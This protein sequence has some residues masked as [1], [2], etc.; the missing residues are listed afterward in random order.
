VTQVL[1]GAAVGLE[2]LEG[3][4]F[5]KERPYTG[6]CICGAIFQ[7]EADR[8]P[9]AVYQRNPAEFSHRLSN[10]DIYA[11][12]L[13]ENWRQK[14]AKTHPEH[15]HES[16]RKS[17]LWC[18]PEAAHRMAAFGIIPLS[19]ALPESET[20]AA[21]YESSPIPKDDVEGT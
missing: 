13:R 15:Q 14:H 18:T 4:K 16:F 10:V 2:A 6:C 5:R 17:G 19:D 8:N 20:E 7:S 12:T 21:L 11:L 3:L 1:H 9:V